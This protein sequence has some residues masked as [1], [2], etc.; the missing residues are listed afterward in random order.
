MDKLLQ[1]GRKVWFIVRVM[2]GHE[3]RRIRSYRLQLQKRLEMAS[4]F[5]PTNCMDNVVVPKCPLIVETFPCKMEGKWYSRAVL[6]E[7][8][9]RKEELRKQPEQVILSEVRQVVQQMQ[10]L[11]QHLDEAEAAIDEYFKPIDKNAKIIADLQLEKE[12][13][14]MKDM[15]KVMQEQIKMQR[16]ITMKRAEAAS[17]ESNDTKVGEKVAEIPPK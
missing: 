13:K 17:V 6:R 7:A 10:A 1:F 2:S 9:A 16:E 3:E 15:A 12:E 5:F 4:V 14:Q 8:Q 11:N